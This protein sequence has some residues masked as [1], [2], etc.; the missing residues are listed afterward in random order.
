[1]TSIWSGQ[2]PNAGQNRQ[3]ILIDLFFYL[4][5]VL[6][7]L[8][9]LNSLRLRCR[10]VDVRFMKRR[11]VMLESENVVREHDDLQKNRQEWF[12]ISFTDCARYTISNIGE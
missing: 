5:I 3:Q 2:H 9:D 12:Y 6:E 8:K 11:C 10:T 7:V 1:M 4:W